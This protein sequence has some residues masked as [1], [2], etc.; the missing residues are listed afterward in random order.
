MKETG[1]A[2]PRRHEKV[3]ILFTDFQGFTQLV[4]S[5]PAITLVE[6]L[7]DIFS[8]F[9]DIMDDEGVEKIETI[10]DAYLAAAGIPD[11]VPD[12]AGRCVRA[13]QRMIAFLRK[14]LFIFIFF[15]YQ[16]QP[17]PSIPRLLKI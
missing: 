6:E 15:R 2:S 9:D 5:I 14:Q 17:H 3:S 13:A 11:E 7:N 8:H 10:G 16:Q 12:H 4:T 1:K